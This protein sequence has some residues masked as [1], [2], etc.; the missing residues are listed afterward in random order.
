MDIKSP[1]EYLKNY[2]GITRE[3]IINAA[4]SMELD[5]FYVLSGEETKD[6]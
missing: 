1:E 6:E 5:T 4:K 2:D 3:D